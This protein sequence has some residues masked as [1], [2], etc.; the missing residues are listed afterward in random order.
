[1]LA[2]EALFARQLRLKGNIAIA[3]T[4]ERGNGGQIRIV[5]KNLSRLPDS[6]ISASSK[7]GKSGFVAIE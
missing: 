1:M 4:A 7:L 6:Q 5:V 2:A 3:A